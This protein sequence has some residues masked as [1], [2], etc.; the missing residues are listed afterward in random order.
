MPA[1]YCY[2][3]PRPA[4]TVDLAVFA[5]D[6]DQLRILL[7][8]R[9]HPPFAGQWALPGGFL[10]ID[11]PV[12]VGARRELKE[13]TGLEVIGPTHFLGVYGDPAR[14][15]RGRT[16][17]LAHAA[18]IQ[19]PSS[20][21]AGSDDASEAAWR[22]A[23]GTTD[24]LAFDHEVI[25]AQAL[26]WLGEGVRS[27]PLALGLLPEVFNKTNVRQMFQALFDTKAGA[28]RWLK[29]LEKAGRIEQIAT[30]RDRLYRAIR[31]G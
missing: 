13:E 1:P 31:A 17:S 14:D 22:P 7:I 28:G 15:P 3:Y 8:R 2:D 21:I 29:R 11:E 24:S 9:K 12:E 30:G 5:L 4:V 26:L 23:R 19:S 16:I 20:N 27:G 10:E 18:L 25:L 6:A